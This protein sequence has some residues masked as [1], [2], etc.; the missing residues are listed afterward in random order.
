MYD[1]LLKVIFE[2]ILKNKIE[3]KWFK[4]YEGIDLQQVIPKND[5][6]MVREWYENGTR[7]V[8]IGRGKGG[9]GIVVGCAI[10]GNQYCKMFHKGLILQT[11]AR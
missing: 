6:K 8:Y 1:F 5:T 2:K 10:I 4:C 7:E 9:V 3:K 11:W